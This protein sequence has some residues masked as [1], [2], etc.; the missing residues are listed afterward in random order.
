MAHLDR[1]TGAT[2]FR[3]LSSL[4]QVGYQHEI[5]HTSSL[6]G[7]LQL[8]PEQKLLAP[9]ILEL[10]STAS[11]AVRQAAGPNDEPV[12]SFA[13]GRIFLQHRPLMDQIFEA[14]AMNI[15]HIEDDGIIPWLLNP[16]TAVSPQSEATNSETED[17]PTPPTETPDWAT[18]V[19]DTTRPT[20]EELEELERQDD[21]VSA[22]D[23]ECL[24]VSP[25]N[26][27]TNFYK[28]IIS[29]AA[30]SSRR[31][32]QSIFLEREVRSAGFANV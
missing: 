14:A 11:L 27:L 16:G 9:E 12:A 10:W 18:L 31:T 26:C 28:I 13:I 4:I 25:V 23:R 2:Y 20:S 32:M 3:W 7:Y 29:R 19:E 5:G 17:G 1:V 8:P 30:F 6:E 21:Q 22:L 15:T 24:L